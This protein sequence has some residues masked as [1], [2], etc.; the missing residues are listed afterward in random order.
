MATTT[1][2]QKV[3]PCSETA[4]QSWNKWSNLI[5][6]QETVCWISASIYIVTKPLYFYIEQPQQERAMAFT[7]CLWFAIVG[8]GMLEK[9]I[10]FVTD[11][12]KLPEFWV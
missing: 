6:L 7:S 10:P 8:N 11:P 1:I 5:V 4:G 9:D 3:P 2:V 12:A